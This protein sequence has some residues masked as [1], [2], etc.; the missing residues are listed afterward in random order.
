[1]FNL[2]IDS[3]VSYLFEHRAYVT[4]EEETT[5]HTQNLKQEYSIESG[6]VVK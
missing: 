3:N 1:M 2:H 5:F 6:R 4:S